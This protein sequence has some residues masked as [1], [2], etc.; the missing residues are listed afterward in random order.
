MIAVVDY[1]TGNLRSVADALRRAGAEFTL[2]AAPAVLRA[3]DRVILPGV[4]EASSAMAKLRERGLDSVIPAL[5]C[6][7]L[8][9][10]I[11]MQLMCLS[12]EEGD[13]EC[14]GIFPTRVRRL[15][16]DPEFASVC[17]GHPELPDAD[18][19]TSGGQ[20]GRIPAESAPCGMEYG[21][22]IAHAALL[23]A[24]GGELRLL[25]ALLCGGPL[26]GDGRHDGVRTTVQCGVS[27]R[28]LLRHAVPP[29]EE[30]R[31]GSGHHSE[32]PDAA[33]NHSGRSIPISPSRGR[34]LG[35][36]Q[37]WKRRRRRRERD[38][39]EASPGNTLKTGTR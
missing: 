28:Q 15:D 30:R 22:G 34:G 39:T 26:H 9:I 16:A 19:R 8:G 38:G 27:A 18:S 14:L 20:A 11:G 10:C 29:R 25:R 33:L 32:L 1:D 21:H 24:S 2:T 13:A 7:V 36:G 6:P 12:S 3:A 35:W 31:G 4:G 17:G 23:G 37:I 5:T